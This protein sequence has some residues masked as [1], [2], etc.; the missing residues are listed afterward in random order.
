MSCCLG[1]VYKPDG[2]VLEDPCAFPSLLE[3]DSERR[4]DLQ[5]E[6]HCADVGQLWLGHRCQGLDS[7]WLGRRIKEL[8]GLYC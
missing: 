8:S 7:G 3:L 6:G 2:F 4:W 5:A 1:L